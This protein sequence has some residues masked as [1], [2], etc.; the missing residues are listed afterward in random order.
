M[1][2]AAFEHLSVMPEEVLHWLQPK[3][4]GIYLDGTLG[5]A[6]H[7]KL[8]LNAADDSRLIGLDRDPAAL[9]KAADVLAPYGD[10]VS[11]QHATFDQAGVTLKWQAF[12]DNRVVGV[13]GRRSKF[14]S[15]ARC[16][17]RQTP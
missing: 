16:D 13:S 15:C 14:S 17:H 4:L 5:G 10:R 12:D 3:S 1:S 9:L 8:I 2:G 11:L 6:G 7:S